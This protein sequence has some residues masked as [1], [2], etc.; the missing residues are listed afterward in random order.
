MSA[1]SDIRTALSVIEKTEE[2]QREP[3]KSCILAIYEN[4]NKLSIV[5]RDVHEMRGLQKDYFKSKSEM[6]LKR[7]KTKEWN[8]DQKLS[9]L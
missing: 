5:L 3:N 2:M 8:V 4:V 6:I 7:S 1:L 9:E